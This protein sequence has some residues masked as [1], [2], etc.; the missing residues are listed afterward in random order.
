M[1]GRERELRGMTSEGVE[2][3]DA[4]RPRKKCFKKEERI[5]SKLLRGK[6]RTANRPLLSGRSLAARTREVGKCGS[7]EVGIPTAESRG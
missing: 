5:F 3:Y 6:I 4:L 1:G 7:R 2:V